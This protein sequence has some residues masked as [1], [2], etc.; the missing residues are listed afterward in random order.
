VILRLLARLLGL[1]A[2]TAAQLDA[3]DGH[4]TQVTE[5]ERR[6]YG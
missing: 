6:F 1:T 5:E 3:L 2:P 4:I